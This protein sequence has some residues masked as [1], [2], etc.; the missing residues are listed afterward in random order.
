[1]TSAK[2]S[3]AH[4]QGQLKSLHPNRYDIPSTHRITRY[5]TTSQRAVRD[6]TEADESSVTVA[7]KSTWYVIPPANADCIEGIVQ[8]RPNMKPS[9]IE[10]FV[11]N[12]LNILTGSRSMDLLSQQQ[13][14][15]KVIP[16]KPKVKWEGGSEYLS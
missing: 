13:V 16:V 6:V 9:E 7:A 15:Q 10:E 8:K 3:A 4:V 5:I 2:M 14:R 1:M 11:L 12:P